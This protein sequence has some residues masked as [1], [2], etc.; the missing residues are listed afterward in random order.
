VTSSIA[1]SKEIDKF[2]QFMRACSH[3]YATGY[4]WYVFPVH[5][6]IFDMGGKCIGCTCEHYRRSDACRDNHPHLYL[7]AGG[8]CV[9]PGKCPRVKWGQKST[10]DRAQIDG[11][12]GHPWRDVCVDTGEILATVPNIGIDCGKSN[13]L[14]FDADTYKKE[15]GT[16]SDLLTIAEQETVTSLT[17][18]GGIHL[19]YNRQDKPYGNSTK[20]LPQG[21]DIRGAG[22]YIVAPPSV[23]KSGVAYAFDDG[24]SPRDVALRPIPERLDAILS[25]A[26]PKFVREDAGDWCADVSAPASVQRSVLA[27]MKV[28]EKGN[29]DAKGQEY[30]D[31]FRWV[32]KSC[33]F[34]PEDDPH[35]EDASAFITVHPNGRIGA[36]CHHNRCRKQIEDA[37]SGWGLLCDRVGHR[38][39]VRSIIVELEL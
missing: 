36:G 22:G 16:L 7:G 6:A 14:V 27:V 2:S 39:T 30:G 13:L 20:G 32:L 34:N 37:G 15:F 1:Q 23:H 11:W 38:R 26:T 19:I 24:Y 29:I 33:P 12:W 8:K 10:T 9:A 28:L 5:T 25:S 17:G 18:G 21:I 35:G 4:G 31:G 3:R